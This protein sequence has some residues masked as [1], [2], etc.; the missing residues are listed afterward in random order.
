MDLNVSSIISLTLQDRQYVT[1]LKS[2]L[3][4][5]VI[6]SPIRVNTTS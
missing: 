6:S 3:L 4:R 2:L 5:E 1:S